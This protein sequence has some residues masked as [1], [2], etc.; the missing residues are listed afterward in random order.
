MATQQPIFGFTLESSSVTSVEYLPINTRRGSWETFST[1]K[2]LVN[3]PTDG[4]F[5][6]MNVRIDTAPGAAAS[7][8][9]YTFA[10]RVNDTPS[11]TITGEILETA[12]EVTVTADH[13]ITAADTVLVQCT[14]ANTPNAFTKVNWNFIW[15]PT[16]DD[17]YL[18]LGNDP[19]ALAPNATEYNKLEC[20]EDSL[21]GSSE[22]DALQLM[23]AAGTIKKLS[24][25]LASTPGAGESY[26]LTSRKNSSD[27]TLTVTLDNA[28]FDKIDTSNSFS[29][30]AGDLLTIKSVG[31]ASANALR[32]RWACVFV[33][34]TAGEIPFIAGSSNNT[35]S[36]ATEYDYVSMGFLWDATI[37]N[38]EIELVNETITLKALY[39]E[40]ASAP[41]SGK[42]YDFDILKDGVAEA[43]LNVEIADTATTGNATG[44]SIDIVD[45]EKI[46]LRLT[47]SAVPTTGDSYW[48]VVFSFG[49]APPASNT[50]RSFSPMVIG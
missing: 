26:V 28:D 49:A 15:E 47:P 37:A 41:G 7:G 8:K 12:T 6:K 48:G 1:E 19:N 22:A 45:T 30:A 40:L 39:A 43:G 21:W 18:L 32:L 27:Q 46:V 11:G 9:K 33:P 25:A 20:A 35:S 31:S 23:P 36:T 3:I 38:H 10:L 5:V 4:K 14:P 42:S 34:T 2:P 50:K 17:E 24:C 16:I 13:S 44:Q 29:V